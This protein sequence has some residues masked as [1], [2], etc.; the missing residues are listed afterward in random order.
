MVRL[1]RFKFEFAEISTFVKWHPFLSHWMKTRIFG[2]MHTSI[3]WVGNG[4]R[5]VLHDLKVMSVTLIVG[6]E[7]VHHCALLLAVVIT[8]SQGIFVV[9]LAHHLM[10]WASLSDAHFVLLVNGHL[11]WVLAGLLAIVSVIVGVG[12]W[13]DLWA[14]VATLLHEMVHQEVA[15][16]CLR[17]LVTSHLMVVLHAVLGLW[18]F[19]RWVLLAWLVRWIVT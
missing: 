7:V 13:H 1:L 11:S 18:Q 16:L 17:L 3:Q 6:D 14:F 15:L 10:E 19:K 4:I 5:L 12:T 8:L 2:I 9:V